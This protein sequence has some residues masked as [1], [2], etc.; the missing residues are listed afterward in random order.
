MSES[1]Y[2]VDESYE[3]YESYQRYQVCAL[4]TKPITYH[5]YPNYHQSIC[6]KINSMNQILEEM[7]SLNCADTHHQH[8]I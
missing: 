2:G 8:K 7:L 5:S 3:S 4:H 6:Q 1:R